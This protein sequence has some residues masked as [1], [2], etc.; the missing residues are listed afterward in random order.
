VE[1]RKK[2]DRTKIARSNILQHSFLEGVEFMN[3]N[4][5]LA[6]IHYDISVRPFMRN[7]LEGEIQINLD[8]GCLY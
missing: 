2:T 5:M 1:E 6:R 7:A 8:N 3:C 4:F